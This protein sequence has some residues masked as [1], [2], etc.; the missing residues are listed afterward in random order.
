M[1]TKHSFTP[2][3][4]IEDPQQNIQTIQLTKRLQV[5]A[6]DKKVI[7]DT[8]DTPCQSFV[9]AFLRAIRACFRAER[10]EAIDINGN[11]NRLVHWARPQTAL[12]YTQARAGEDRVGPVIGTGTAPLTNED[13]RLAAQIKNGTETGQIEYQHT[14]VRGPEIKTDALV[15]TTERIF[16]NRTPHTQTVKEC[17]LYAL[18]SD[19]LRPKFHC[20]IRDL[21][22]PEIPLPP[23]HGNILQYKILTRV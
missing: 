17:G 5:I 16:I 6:P 23:E 14:D 2:I 1:T 21:V 10:T 9:I 19:F 20:L 22:I 15:I 8:G 3:S 13:S 4:T 7:H 11:T 18:G 12:M